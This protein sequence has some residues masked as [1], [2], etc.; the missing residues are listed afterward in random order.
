TE[1]ANQVTCNP[2]PPARR[3]PGTVGVG[4]GIEVAIMDWQGGLLPPCT[5]GEIVVRGASVMH[6]YHNNA[7][8]NLAAFRD[9]WF[10]TGDIGYLDEEGYLTVDG[11]IKDLIIRGGENISPAEVDAVLLGHPAVADA[12]CF[13]VPDEKYGEEIHAAVILKN[14][15]D[16]KEL[17]DFLS[18]RLAAFKVPKVIH[19]TDSLPRTATNKV[20]R[21]LIAARFGGGRQA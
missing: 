3:K 12:V 20:Q 8:A 15:A 13:G 5:A 17:R 18:A 10:R 9:G 21:H 11:R 7:T 2:L 6:G 4:A 14:A 19:I 1:A 16:A